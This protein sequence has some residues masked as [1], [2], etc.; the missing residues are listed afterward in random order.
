M[1]FVKGL[2]IVFLIIIAVGIYKFNYLL[3]QE[4]YDVDSNKITK[5]M[6]YTWDMNEDNRND[7][8]DDD[9]CDH[10]D[11]YS[12]PRYKITG[13]EKGI[14]FDIK[15]GKWVDKH[16]ICHTCTPENGFYKDG[17]MK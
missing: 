10:T 8:E 7:C 11:D 2:G 17:T 1:K 6:H 3:N 5:K 14:V 13:V 15:S 9:S 16:G 4:R 12:L